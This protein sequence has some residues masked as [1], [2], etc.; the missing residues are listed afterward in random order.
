M[1]HQAHIVPESQR[2]LYHRVKWAI[3][4]IYGV[5]PSEW[6]EVLD[7]IFQ[8]EEAAD[9]LIKWEL[10]ELLDPEPRAPENSSDSLEIVP[11]TLNIDWLKGTRYPITPP[12][13]TNPDEVKKQQLIWKVFMELCPDYALD[14]IREEESMEE[15]RAPDRPQVSPARDEVTE[16]K[17]E[18]Q[19]PIPPP[20]PASPKPSKKHRIGMWSMVMG[21]FMC[22]GVVF[23]L[24]WYA[25]WNRGT[26]EVIRPEPLEQGVQV[27]TVVL[28]DTLMVYAGMDGLD[29]LTVAFYRDPATGGDVP[30]I[31]I[32]GREDE[33]LSTHLQIRD[34]APG[35]GTAFARIS[36]E[37]VNTL[38][39]V[40]ELA[41]SPVQISSGYR[42]M[43]LNAG[44]GGV[45]NSMHIAGKAADLWSSVIAPLELADLVLE[46]SQ[47]RV[48]V[49]LGATYIHMDVRENPTSW[50]SDGAI[51]DEKSFD[52]WV[53]LRC[54]DRTSEVDR[55]QV[56]LS[57]LLEQASAPQEEDSDTVQV[58]TDQS[59]V[60]QANASVNWAKA[61]QRIILGFAR[62][63]MRKKIRGAVLLD[64][65]K[66]KVQKLGAFDYLLTYIPVNS[67]EVK[68]Y[69]VTHLIQSCPI[70]RY[71]VYVVIGP[72]GRHETGIMSY[73]NYP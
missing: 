51:M 40:M 58:A 45:E 62:I 46:A 65:R 53:R 24:Q 42:H 44:T 37:L 21:V 31:P 68:Q 6:D 17:S 33:Y 59:Q 13:T 47:C 32:A 64:L 20:N 16:Q 7:T 8:G 1:D 71:F 18:I 36:D 50:V 55:S 14:E 54:S 12:Q 52:D 70:D 48:S 61:Y 49:G 19:Q 38:D 9:I 57:D 34:F 67:A 72:D 3:N 23:G 66:E 26:P 60:A 5:D 69:G 39:A 63:Q 2:D 29:S 11:N 22:L 30:L 43:A 28:M 41:W 27:G 15:K 56:I 10:R 73:Q 4:A 25:T 35:D